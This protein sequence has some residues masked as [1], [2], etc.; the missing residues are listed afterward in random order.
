MTHV[1]CVYFNR[2]PRVALATY[3]WP[4]RSAPYTLRFPASRI[5]TFFHLSAGKA[6]H[7]YARQTREIHVSLLLKLPYPPPPPPPR[8]NTII[9]LPLSPPKFQRL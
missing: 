1:A 5:V 6:S 2:W 7:G 8:L 9:H 4:V 3:R